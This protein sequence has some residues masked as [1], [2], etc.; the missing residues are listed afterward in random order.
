[1]AFNSLRRLASG[2]AKG[3]HFAEMLFMGPLAAV[4]IIALRQLRLVAPSPIWLIPLILV[5]GQ[6]ASTSTG[7][8]WDRSHTR[9][10]L[11]LRIGTQ[12]ILVTAIIY[13]T[14]WGPALAIGLVLVGQ[15]SLAIT[16]SESLQVVL[17]W[18]LGCLAVGEGLIALGWAPSLIPE[19]EVQGLAILMGIGIIFSYPS[20]L[21]A[22]KEKEQAASLTERRER[23]FRAL[24]HSSSDLVF[25]VDQAGVVT[26]AS[27]SCAIVLGHDPEDVV[28]SAAGDLVHQDDIGGLR[29]AVDEVVEREGAS[30]EFS[31]RAHHQNGTWRWLEGVA[32]N[33][34][35]D[36]AVEGIVINARD[37]TQ[38]RERTERQAAISDLGREVL[39]STTLG[40]ALVCT[41]QTCA[42]IMGPHTCRIVGAT[43]ESWPEQSLG[44]LEPSDCLGGRVNAGNKPVLVVPVGDPKQPLAFIQ[45]FHNA[46]VTTDDC[47]FIESVSGLLLSVIVRFRAED[48][49]RHQ[50][51]HDPLTGLANRVLFNDR[52][53]YAL[54]RRTRI[55]EFVAVMIVDLDGFKNINDSLGHLAGDDLLIGVAGRFSQILRDPDTI[56][57]LGGDEFAILI[58]DLETED[59]AEVIAQRLI[60]TLVDPLSLPDKEVVVGASIGIAISNSADARAERLLSAA[61]AAM[62]QAKRAGKGCYRVFK[63][64]M[65]EAAVDRM[66]FEQDLRVAIKDHSLTVSYQPIINLKTGRV[67][68][69]EALA[70]W[71]HPRHGWVSPGSFIP[72]AE[73]SGLIVELGR[74]ILVE[75]C[76]Q[77]SQWR[78]DQSELSPTVSVNVSRIQLAHPLFVEHVVDALARTGLDASSLIVEVTESVLAAESRIITDTLN[79]CDRWVRESR[80]M[81]LELAT[82]HSPL[83]P[84]FQSTSSRSTSGS[85]TTSCTT[86]RGVDSSRPS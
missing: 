44:F 15:E 1:M 85:W 31:I 49:I 4:A 14:G 40:A 57:R 34:L 10:R 82:R 46:P 56:A 11:N 25:A 21:S 26:Y 27:P 29:A 66:S 71:N 43:Q 69:F 6:A 51:L 24:V 39:R 58:D 16:G 48:A 78:L 81:I 70:R 84:T 32:T 53:E 63:A 2:E 72:L 9:L 13:T 35:S 73:D 64:A 61:D 17:T 19:P 7:F 79:T 28:G 50:A 62:Y 83:S 5:V 60:D 41:Q 38:R 37:V 67:S 12:L 55:S 76:Q 22:L 59:H 54:K 18:T 86:I 45:I 30:V 8:W 75:A 68:S 47:Q 33:L 52:L 23:R 42:R 80:S 20:L 3:A 36:P 77:A 65:H 74:M